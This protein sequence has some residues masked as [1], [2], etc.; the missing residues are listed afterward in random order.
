VCRPVQRDYRGQAGYEPHTA[1]GSG[2]SAGCAIALCNT[3]T[4]LEAA[5]FKTGRASWI[6]LVVRTWHVIAFS[7]VALVAVACTSS[8][9][10]AEPSGY[11]VPLRRIVADAN[12]QN[13]G[14]PSY[15]L[16]ALI[17]WPHLARK[18]RCPR[19][20]Q[21][22]PSSASATKAA[23]RECLLPDSSPDL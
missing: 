21:R 5:V 6:D 3:I 11:S 14:N 22:V 15:R 16:A 8:T 17:A 18:S 2:A 13:Q 4:S 23:A 9:T 12:V 1:A 19:Q 10:T 7:S 20:P